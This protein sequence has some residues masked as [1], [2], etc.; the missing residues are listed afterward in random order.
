MNTNGVLELEDKIVSGKALQAVKILKMSKNYVQSVPQELKSRYL[1][2]GWTV[3][4]EFRTKVRM[5]KQKPQDELFEDRIW[6][7][8]ANL[9]Y[10]QLNK[11]RTLRISY[12]SGGTS[13][14]QQLDVLA[15]DDEMVLI[16][17]CKSAIELRKCSFKETIDAYSFQMDKLECALQELFPGR[18]I[19]FLLAT[20][21]YQLLDTDRSRLKNAGIY[22]LEEAELQ[23]YE[24]LA[25]HL[26]P[27]ARYQFLG[28]L[29]AGEQV[30][31]FENRVP[32][33][34][35]EVEGKPCYLFVIEPERLLK[36]SYV[37]HQNEV[38]E[39]LL[40]SYQRIMKKKR[41]LEVQRFLQ[42]DGFFPNNVIVSLNDVSF[43]EAGLQVPGAKG[44]LGVLSLPDRYRSAF[45]IDGQHRLYGYSGLEQRHTQAIPVTALV[46]LDELEQKRLFVEINE[47]QKSVQKNLRNTLTADLEWN[48]R[49]YS[50][51][52]HA[53]RLT[54]ARR[55]GEERD[56][57]ICGR[58]QIGEEK[59]GYHNELTLET[60]DQALRTSS[61]LRQFDNNNETVRDGSFDRG[62]NQSTMA[63]LYPFLVQCLRFFAERMP[64]EWEREDTLLSVNMGV[65]AVIKLADD[66]VN[67]LLSRGE[68]APKTDRTCELLRK[69]KPYLEPVVDW[70]R[71]LPEQERAAF[72]TNYGSGGRVKLWRAFQLAVYS[73]VPDF[74]PIGLAD[75]LEAQQQRGSEQTH[76]LLKNLEEKLRDD[77]VER[78]RRR[79]GESW[80]AAGLPKSLYDR[81]HREAADRNYEQPQLGLK[82]EDCL[83]AGDLREIVLHGNHWGELFAGEYAW[84]E[85]VAG[86]GK[87][88]A[89][90]WLDRLE[91][92]RRKEFA[93]LTEEDGRLIQELC[94]WQAD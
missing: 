43:Q 61:F 17:E 10:P 53:L 28:N 5:K 92:L 51:Q 4:R 35:Y 25:L 46:A 39:Q 41:L 37:L 2:E 45:L 24:E 75:Y 87:E 65:F 31:D 89:T 84:P 80:L 44:W 88:E 73:R 78:L 66:A 47:N 72:R 49:L 79:Y 23:Y 67:L 76:R 60:L 19:K 30:R 40:S 59:T 94:A 18:K 50:E 63:V 82:P 32:A 56:S 71:K 93:S 36:I 6:L 48:S 34:R 54:I 29:F 52:R 27:S 21:G 90:L 86:R 33:I 64:E 20:K 58:V 15:A 91:E 42:E 81:I 16:T 77:V 74:L 70:L 83:T 13:D 22:H 11:D 38:N 1:N 57:P 12:R 62:T 8:F 68:I 85:A 3:E 9:G 14:S 7:L 55:L 26:V 69:I